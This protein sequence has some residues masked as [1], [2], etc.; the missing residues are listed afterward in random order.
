MNR[1][2][3][4]LVHMHTAELPLLCFCLD[5]TLA[6]E[7]QQCWRALKYFVILYN[8]KSDNKNLVVVVESVIHESRN[9]LAIP[10]C[11]VGLSKINLRCDQSPV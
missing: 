3:N 6:L 5:L 7:F 4:V 2:M 9:D 10:L 1:Y 11:T 8:E